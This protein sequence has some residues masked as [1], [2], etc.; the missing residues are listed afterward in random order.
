MLFA[1]SFEWPATIDFVA[2]GPGSR[3]GTGEI[4]ARGGRHVLK[5]PRTFSH[6]T[7]QPAVRA[8]QT[9][10]NG[11]PAFLTGTLTAIDGGLGLEI[12]EVRLGSDDPTP[13]YRSVTAEFELLSSI[14][15]YRNRSQTTQKPAN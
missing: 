14:G 2:V 15:T 1:S 11:Q 13:L 8:L 12:D 6:A 4:N 10:I 3:D 7:G 9:K 5:S